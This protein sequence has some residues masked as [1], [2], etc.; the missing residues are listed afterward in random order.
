M[1]PADF[2]KA[3]RVLPLQIDD[4][5]NADEVQASI[6]RLGRLRFFSDVRID[7]AKGSKPGSEHVIVRVVEARTG[8]F[9]LGGGVSTA[10]GFFGNISLTQRNFDILDLPKGFRDFLDGRSLTGAGQNLTISLQP[11][12]ERS[13]FSIEFTEP[14]LLGFPVPLTLQGLIRDRQR[15]DWLES[16]RAGRFAGKGA[17]GAAA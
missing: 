17:P 10:T 3:H 15:E 5:I 7:F 8:S 2:A 6:S 9:V 16:R 11:G 12:R 13:Q 1:L 14:W 4:G